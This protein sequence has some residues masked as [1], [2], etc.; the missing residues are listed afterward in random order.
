MYME[1]SEQDMQEMF[2]MPIIYARQSTRHKGG[3]DNL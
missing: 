1:T 2:G 3:E